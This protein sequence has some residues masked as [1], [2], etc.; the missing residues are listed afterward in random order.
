MIN[1]ERDTMLLAQDQDPQ[2]VL[3][4]KRI[5]LAY[6]HPETTQHTDDDLGIGNHKRQR[7]TNAS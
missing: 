3:D 1:G 4:A 7:T 5:Q 2:E 6:R